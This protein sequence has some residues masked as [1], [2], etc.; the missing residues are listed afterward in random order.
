MKKIILLTAFVLVASTAFLQN[1]L[2]N[3]GALS[4]TENQ[5]RLEYIDNGVQA[6]DLNYSFESTQFS[7]KEVKGS[8]YTILSRRGFTH[9]KEVGKPAVPAQ[10]KIIAVPIGATA[11][12]KFHK[13]A[14]HDETGYLCYPA[15]PPA[16]DTYGAPEPEFTIDEEF[17]TRDVYYPANPVEVV[18]RMIIRGMELLVVQ[19]RPVQY[20]P[21]KQTFRLYSTLD[22]SIQFEGGSEFVDVTQHSKDFLKRY[23]A[24]LLNKTSVEK[25]I[26]LKKDTPKPKDGDAR[27]YIIVT[28]NVYY[29]VAEKLAAWK[30]QLGYKVD[31]VTQAAWTTQEVES[32]IKTRYQNWTP[33][34]DYFLIIG[35]QQDVPAQSMGSHVTDLYYACMDGGGDFWPDMAKGRISAA[36]APNALAIVNK[37][38]KYESQPVSSPSFYSSVTHAA[39][40]QESSQPGYAER[41]FAQTAEDVL[42]YM[43]DHH[44]KNV[45]R[46]YVTGSST[47]PT[48]WNNGYYSAGEPLPS[49]LLK[50]T[51]PWN[52]S[53]ADINDAINSGNLYVLHRDHGFENG[54]GDPYYDK[55][56][57]NSL[58]NGDLTPVVFSINCLTGKFNEAE[59][60]AERFLR[61]AP[62]GAVG[63]FAHS[64]VSYSG[65]NDGLAMGIFD[66]IWAS[67]GL[68]P[69]FTGS[70]GIPFPNVTPHEPILTMGNVL[71]HSLIRMSETWGTNQYTNELFHYFGD[72]AMK[73]WVD[74]PQTITATYTNTITC[75]VDSVIHIYNSSVENAIATLVV[76]GILMATIELV[77]GE[78]YL[79]FD[80]VAGE[81]GIVTL[82]ADNHKPLVSTLY[83]NG[84]CPKSKIN[85]APSHFC[86]SDS[87]WFVSMS[88]G[89][90]TDYV[91]DFGPGA[92]PQ[93]ATDSGP[94]TVYYSIPGPKTISLSVTGPSGN[95]THE[96]MIEIDTD[97]KFYMPDIGTAFASFCYGVLFDDGGA[98]NYSDETYSTF[99]IEPDG[100]SGITLYFNE[101]NFEE[102]WDTLWVIDGDIAT[103]TTIGGFT[104]NTLPMGGVISTTQG[105]VT[106]IQ[107]TDQAVNE[108]GFELTW[109]CNYP[110]SPPHSNFMCT[111]INSCMGEAVFYDITTNVPQSWEWDFGDGNTSLLQNP[112]HVYQSNGAFT[113]TLITTNSFGSDTISYPSLIEID[114]PLTP[115]FQDSAAICG[116]GTIDLTAPS[117]GITQWYESDTALVPLGIGDTMQVSVDSSTVFYV[118]NVQDGPSL[119]GAKFNDAGDGAYYS[120]STVHYLVFDIYEEIILKSVKVFASGDGNRTIFLRGSNGITLETI[121]VFIPD[122]ESRVNLNWVIPAGTEYQLAAEGSPY[123]WRNNA[124]LTYPYDIAGKG[125]VTHSSASSNPT[126]YYYFF[127]DWEIEGPDCYSPRIPY[128]VFV[129]NNEPE[130]GFTYDILNDSVVAFTNSSTD[131]MTYTWYF[132]DGTSSASKNPQHQ[133][134]T[135][136]HYDVILVASNPCGDD[137]ISATIAVGIE[138]IEN[139]ADAIKLFPNP[140]H[141]E[142]TLVLPSAIG[143][144]TEICLYNITGQCLHTWQLAKRQTRIVLPVDNYS[145]GVYWLRI[146]DTIAKKLIIQK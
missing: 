23:P 109:T 70:G 71:N 144:E 29:D 36:S 76:D 9:T 90:I 105:K 28:T 16:P 34:P 125:S 7:E 98:G 102:G 130:A 42:R 8:S 101:F 77:N 81:T 47:N 69:N 37:I 33:K 119:Y 96:R 41:R 112:T 99:V 118:E 106:I 11:K 114:R 75:G 78:G 13:L 1:K 15:Q 94:H 35:D 95:D 137:T 54:W 117:A 5:T 32:A 62:G 10:N 127:Y 108:A 12:I 122:G 79:H 72:P 104:G 48:N 61:K 89:T 50:P 124:S 91:W 110:N 73:M 139:A 85:I 93:T 67:P 38:I 25:E 143:E 53:A 39:Y 31:I 19:I 113:V 97:C 49:Y 87:V 21:Q 18:D 2:I 68:V 142:V 57:I 52:G 141:N 40:F 121:T 43:T 4:D 60:F 74:V 116:P 64:E 45:N 133:Y 88:T 46:V 55:S 80:P 107:Q 27:D 22:F 14:F 129:M 66:A 132:D 3:A 111:K 140:A 138:D 17:Y 120:Y 65:Y 58:S 20:N 26:A 51:F 131:A 24:A 126:G 56:D 135:I 146:G 123:L 6:V 103:G 30:Q 136:G 82:S 115:Q 59:C 92:I 84:D 128:N 145:P 63:V 134:A 44:G 86:P 100:A 83:I